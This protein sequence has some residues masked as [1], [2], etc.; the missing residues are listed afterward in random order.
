MMSPLNLFDQLNVSPRTFR[1]GILGGFIVYSIYGLLDI[2]MLPISY[3]FAWTV[4]IILGSILIIPFIL[5]FFHK[6]Q[7]HLGILTIFSII[8]SQIGI[9]IMI[10]NAR[11][12]E[13]GHDNYY[14]GMILIILWAAFIFRINYKSILF[15]TLLSILLYIIHIILDIQ[16]LDEEMKGRYFALFFNNFLFFISMSFLAVVGSYLIDDYHKKLGKEK[17]DLE[18]ALERSNESDRIKSS[19]L[20]TMSHEIRTPLNG[21]IGF[22]DILINDES[23]EDRDEIYGIINKQG[24]QLLNIL[25]TILEFSQLQKADDLGTKNEV[26]LS[27]LLDHLQSAFSNFI[28]QYQMKNAILSMEIASEIQNSTLNLHYEKFS[29]VVTAILENSVKFGGNSPVIL[30]MEKVQEKDLLISIRDHGIGLADKEGH[31]VFQDFRQMDSGHDR[32]YDGIGMGLAISNKIIEFMHG[33]IWYKKNEGS[34]TTFF[35]HL[36]DCL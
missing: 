36:P 29:S 17:L 6:Y 10:L 15:L 2:Y 27:N 3:P 7:K 20:S 18:H 21:I 22:S 11:P 9:Y 23:I 24:Y 13:M 31:I 32:K 12:E 34:G 1:I 16:M 14:L 25:S 30:R 19:F 28:H 4:R 33:S 8:L 26:E 5:S 35:I